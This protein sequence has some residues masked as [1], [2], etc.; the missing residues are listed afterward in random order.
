[1]RDLKK[2]LAQQIEKAVVPVRVE[3]PNP[4]KQT[5]ISLPVCTLQEIANESRLVLEGEERLSQLVYQLDMYHSTAEGCEQL[6][7][8]VNAVMLKAGFTRSG[9]MVEYRSRGSTRRTMR[10]SGVLDEKTNQIYK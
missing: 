2:Q 1:M 3:L 10:F 5:P 7:Q 9:G 4:N 8:A 6:C